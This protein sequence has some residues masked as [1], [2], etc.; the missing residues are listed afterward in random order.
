MKRRLSGMYKKL[1]SAFGPR[2]WWPADTPEEVIFGAILTQNAAWANVVQALQALKGARLLSFRRIAAADEQALARLVRPA[3]YFNQKARALREFAGYFGSRYNFSIERMRRRDTLELRDELLGVYRIGPETADSI[4]L[5]ALEKPVFVID[6]YT[7]RIL[8]RHGI[9]SMQHSY[10]D[11]QQLFMKHL[12][13]DAALY[14][15]F[16]AQLVHLG[17]QYCKPKPLCDECPLRVKRP[18]KVQGSTV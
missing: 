4:L 13:P 11:F 10:A 5:Y 15:D 7:Q 12:R 8:S 1:H 14:N 17:N 2:K 9:L 16:H 6:A 18:F 3:R